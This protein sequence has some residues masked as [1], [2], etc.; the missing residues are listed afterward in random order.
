MYNGGEETTNGT[1][2]LSTGVR[3]I[4]YLASSEAVGWRMKKRKTCPWNW[5][6]DI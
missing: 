3:G 2:N 5:L 4:G 1:E 6:E